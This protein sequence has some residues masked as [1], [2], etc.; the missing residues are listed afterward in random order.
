M[1]PIDKRY[2]S[3]ADTCPKCH[4]WRNTQTINRGYYLCTTCSFAWEKN[5]PGKLGWICPDHQCDLQATVVENE[6]MLYCDQCDITYIIPQGIKEKMERA[7]IV[8]VDI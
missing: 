4:N 6:I 7:L 1:N 5:D 8:E 2:I 3:L